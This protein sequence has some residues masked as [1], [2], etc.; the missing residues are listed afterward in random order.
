MIDAHPQT[1]AEIAAHLRD[2]SRR[3]LACGSAMCHHGD[4]GSEM[5]KHGGEM[6]GAAA[7]ANQWADEIDEEH[8]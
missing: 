3:M 5:S 4:E 1:P 7:M 8:P 6:I 2:I